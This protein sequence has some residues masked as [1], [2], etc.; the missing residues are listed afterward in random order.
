MA[1]V[2]NLFKNPWVGTVEIKNRKVALLIFNL[3]MHIIIVYI[4]DCPKKLKYSFKGKGNIFLRFSL[5]LFVAIYF[6]FERALC[7]QSK[8]SLRP[9]PISQRPK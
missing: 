5:L 4:F 3:S 9:K 8:L 7:L 1:V 6:T 2:L